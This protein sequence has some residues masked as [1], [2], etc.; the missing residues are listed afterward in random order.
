MANNR[1]DL[2]TYAAAYRPKTIVLDEVEYVVPRLTF[3][4]ALELDQTYRTLVGGA[5]DVSQV[6]EK[7]SQLSGIPAEILGERTVDEI[8]AIADFLSQSR[9]TDRKRLAEA[10]ANG[11]E[12]VSAPTS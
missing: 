6:L 10:L 12:A 5:G 7:L 2:N 1:L 4:A 3:N 8:G 9:G 11:T